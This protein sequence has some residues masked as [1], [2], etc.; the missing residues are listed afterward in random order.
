MLHYYCWIF[1]FLIVYVNIFSYF[2][3]AGTCFNFNRL[4][5]GQCNLAYMWPLQT[6]CT[7]AICSQN[8]FTI[9]QPATQ[10]NYT[11]KEEKKRWTIYLVFWSRG[12]RVGYRQRITCINFVALFAFC[13][14]IWTVFSLFLFCI[15][16][17]HQMCYKRSV[18]FFEKVDNNSKSW[19]YLCCVYGMNMFCKC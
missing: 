2:T 5:I 11:I 18:F 17:K 7:S 8:K 16:N 1:Y 19:K 15:I 9:S 13:R 12:I 3:S 14:I 6:C 10:Q 4:S